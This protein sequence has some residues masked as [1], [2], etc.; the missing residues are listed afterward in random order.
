MVYITP[1]F[2][3]TGQITPKSILKNYSK[4]QKNHKMTKIN[5][6][7]L[8][9]SRSIQSTWKSLYHPLTY[10]SELHNPLTYETA[11]ITT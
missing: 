4:S 9:M 3:K 6:V 5:C 1:E 11:H 7:G 8:Q 2:S 10:Q